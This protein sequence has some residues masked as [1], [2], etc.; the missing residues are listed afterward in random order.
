[1]PGRVIETEIDLR[2][3]K[4]VPYGYVYVGNTRMFFSSPDTTMD[5]TNKKLEVWFVRH[6]PEP[7]LREVR[8]VMSALIAAGYE[9]Q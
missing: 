7:T 5:S 9:I 2:G 1:M 4:E 6:W 8:A 3:S